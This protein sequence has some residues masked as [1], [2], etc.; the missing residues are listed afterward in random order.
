MKY[1]NPL[2]GII[3]PL[4]TPLKNNETLDV[5]SLERLIE[6]LIA[7]GVHGL[8]I[9]GTTGEEQSLS[10]GVR[11]QM[12]K[13]SCRINNGRLPLLA[14]VTD[15]SIVESI[16]LAHVAADCGAD[17][18]VSA[19][20]YYFATGQPELAQFY[21]ELVPQLPLP[22]FLYNMPSHV[23]V[24][25]APDTVRRIAQNPQ[26][27]GFKDSSANAVYFQSVMY[28]MRERPD[29]AMLVGPEEITG[30][31][32]LMGAHGGING[33]ANMFPELY[34]A[35][36]DAARQG[37]LERVRQLQQFIMQISSTIYT[38]GKHGSSYLKGLKCALSLLGVIN[39]DFV[40]SPFYKF[41]A[42]ERE[43]I[44][45][46]LDALPIENGKLMI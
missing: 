27:V 36:Y 17:G 20:P 2:C 32:V 22:V 9:L 40:A 6:H 13:E 23:K 46:A 44:K 24:S 1:N 15:T 8:F 10:Y 3:P 43:K 4:V 33:G 37:Q 45:E 19:P 39:D 35:M 5:E 7:G 12:I 25:F 38:V 16:K 30:E 26:V 42:P 11:K 14:C 34:V 18:V 41:N 21:E 29:F 28:K 31:C